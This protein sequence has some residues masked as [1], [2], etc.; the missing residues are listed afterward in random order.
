MLVVVGLGLGPWVLVLGSWSITL[1]WSCA[2]VSCAWL[3]YFLI[4]DKTIMTTPL[5]NIVSIL[6]PGSKKRDT[7]EER[8]EAIRGKLKLLGWKAKKS[9]RYEWLNTRP[10]PHALRHRPFS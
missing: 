4:I 6:M 8:F 5:Q 7:T 3:S 10:K 2:L 1:S 9:A